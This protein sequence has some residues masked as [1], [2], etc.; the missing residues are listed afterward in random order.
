MV[1]NLAASVMIPALS[2]NDGIS[3]TTTLLSFVFLYYLSSFRAALCE[4]ISPEKRRPFL[5]ALSPRFYELAVCLLSVCFYFYAK[6]TAGEECC[7]GETRFAL[8]QKNT[9]E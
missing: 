3:R 5:F 9:K 2:R 1:F 4:V 8:N 6:L 7:D